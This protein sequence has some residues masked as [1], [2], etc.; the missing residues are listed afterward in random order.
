MET[1]KIK[2]FILPRKKYGRG[3]QGEVILELCLKNEDFIK[4]AIAGRNSRQVMAWWKHEGIACS[5]LGRSS[6]KWLRH[7][8]TEM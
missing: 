7:K 1:Q 2:R 6:S 8:L 5:G 3:M 4:Q